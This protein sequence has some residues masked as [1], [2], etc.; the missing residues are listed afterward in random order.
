M[1]CHPRPL[2][3]IDTNGTNPKIISELLP[4][5]N[6]IAL[7]LKGP[8]NKKRLRKITGNIMDPNLIIETFNVVN[9]REG[10]DFE[11]FG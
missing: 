9:K 7:D 8:L 1:M 5:I 4:H 3:I 11:V 6:R 2:K 10:I